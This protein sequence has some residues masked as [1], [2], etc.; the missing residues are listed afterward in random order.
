MS[1][2]EHI[3]RWIALILCELFTI[4]TIIM[5]VSTGQ[6]SRLPMA[7]TTFFLLLIPLSA[8]GLFRFRLTLPVYL[9]S[10]FYA[11]GPMLGQCHN[12]YYI[13]GWWDKLLHGLGGVMFAL[14]GLFIF[15]RYEDKTAKNVL[16]AA[17]FALCFSM[18]ISVLWEFCE[19]AADSFWGMDM[20]QDT[21]ISGFHS[22]L[23]GD[24]LGATGFIGDISEVLVNGS[25]L[26]G[27]IDIGLHDTMMDM[28]WETLGA[29]AVAVAHIC[30]KGKHSVFKVSQ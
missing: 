30:S 12:L 8:E 23:L 11:L 19:F 20:Q 26:P 22:Y 7:I 24:Q 10:L 6:Y 13:L 18:A 5:V 2:K 17:L 3:L 1:K 9:I 28:I 21:L 14:V 4:G 27:Y 29:V 25:P 15:Q 16:M